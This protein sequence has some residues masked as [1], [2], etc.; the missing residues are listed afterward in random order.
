[1]LLRQ[2]LCPLLLLLVLAAMHAHHTLPLAW[3]HIRL[4]C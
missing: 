1:M 4:G 2:Q 3:H